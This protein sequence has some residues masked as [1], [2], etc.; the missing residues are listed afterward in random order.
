MALS[1]IPPGISFLVAFLPR[2]FAPP[3]LVY[4]LLHVA[5]LSTHPLLSSDSAR[6]ALYVLAAPIFIAVRINYLD[7][8]A[9]REAKKLGA[10]LVPT[11][12][13]KWPGNLDLLLR[14]MR[15]WDE[16]YM[17]E[18]LKEMGQKH[19]NTVNARFLWDNFVSVPCSFSEMEEMLTWARVDLHD[20]AGQHQSYPCFELCQRTSP[21]FHP[22]LGRVY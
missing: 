11:M 12:Q 4:V 21:A 10:E 20:G 5:P 3:L 16:D 15:T 18:F 9:R 2:L 1:A 14:M 8:V 6:I 17:G 13:G 19:G 22:P 7:F